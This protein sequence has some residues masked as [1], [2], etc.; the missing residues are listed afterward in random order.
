MYFCLFIGLPQCECKLIK[1]RGH[2]PLTYWVSCMKPNPV[3]TECSFTGDLIAP[4]T[5]KDLR[6]TGASPVGVMGPLCCVVTWR[7]HALRPVKF[8]CLQTSIEDDTCRKTCTSNPW[9]G[10]LRQPCFH[11]V[12]NSVRGWWSALAIWDWIVTLTLLAGWL[13]KG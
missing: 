2:S 1:G 8:L 13:W 6:R 3:G 7:Y 10:H 4:H 5:L 12:E 9:F 11:G